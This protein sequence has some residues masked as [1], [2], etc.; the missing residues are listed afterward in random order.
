MRQ[1]F[2]SPVA[3]SYGFFKTKGNEGFRTGS[4]MGTEITIERKALEGVLRQVDSL[5]EN[6]T[7]LKEKLT[8]NT[9]S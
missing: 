8:K 2:T 7:Q 3:G 6:L 4:M 5:L 1:S 9:G